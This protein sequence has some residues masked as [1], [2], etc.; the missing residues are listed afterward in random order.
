MTLCSIILD[1]IEPV[2]DQTERRSKGRS[3]LVLSKGIW[4]KLLKQIRV[5]L[6]LSSIAANNPTIANH[7]KNGNT[8]AAPPS[9]LLG[10]FVTVAKLNSGDTSIF[11]LLA[12]DTLSFAE[13]PDQVRLYLLL[14]LKNKLC[15][16]LYCMSND[17]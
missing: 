5:C 12:E 13:I 15:F 8:V 1:V 10:M 6:L 4:E 9:S 17:V 7:N 16:R 11:K 3:S 2:S 14:Y